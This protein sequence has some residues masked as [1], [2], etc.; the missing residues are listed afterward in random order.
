MEYPTKLKIDQKVT[1]V[2]SLPLIFSIL[3]LA[4]Q[5]NA[6]LRP[7][8]SANGVFVDFSVLNNSP[9]RYQNFSTPSVSK[10]RNQDGTQEP[11]NQNPIS[12]L[13]IDRFPDN[14]LNRKTLSPRIR[15]KN[16]A[17]FEKVKLKKPINSRKIVPIKKNKVLKKRLKK[18]AKKPQTT[19]NKGMR[20][21]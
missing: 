19:K 7:W 15:L 11:P 9:R 20:N 3:L 12:R 2:F 5:A 8:D 17:S 18:L 21:P 16:P 14:S 13:L 1:I 4:P 10:F 6:Q